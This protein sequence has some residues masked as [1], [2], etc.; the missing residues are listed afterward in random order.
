M[1][2]PPVHDQA[3][4]AWPRVQT[5]GLRVTAVA[6]GLAG[7]EGLVASGYSLQGPTPSLAMPLALAGL[8]LLVASVMMLIP[9]RAELVE[10]ILGGLAGGSFGVTLAE[11]SAQAATIQDHYKSLWVPAVLAA[12]LVSF[13]A[14]RLE[15]TAKRGDAADAVPNS[16]AEHDE[17]LRKGVSG[18]DTETIKRIKELLE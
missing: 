2:F 15:A 8:G 1:P 16:T 7:A 18:G 5:W 13:L 17:E 6:T 11:M 4:R 10:I 12:L 14:F 3:R 9:A